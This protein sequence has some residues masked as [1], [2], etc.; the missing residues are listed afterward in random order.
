MPSPDET[1][2][3]FRYPSGR[4]KFPSAVNCG[5]ALCGRPA[6]L[7]KKSKQALVSPK[8][9]TSKTPLTINPSVAGT[10]DY[11]VLR[12]SDRRPSSYSVSSLAPLVAPA[13]GSL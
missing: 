10:P 7:D 9:Q 8:K 2:T 4:A 11:G 12:Y 5:A 6:A 13:P 1:Y 3:H